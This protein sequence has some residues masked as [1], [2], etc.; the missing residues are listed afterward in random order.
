MEHI[1]GFT[2][3]PLDATIGQLPAPYHPNGRHGQRI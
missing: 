1:Q 2:S 3:K